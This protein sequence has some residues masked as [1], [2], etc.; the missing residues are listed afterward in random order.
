MRKELTSRLLTE[1]IF[2]LTPFPPFF[3]SGTS[4]G[5]E[6]FERCTVTEGCRS[7]ALVPCRSFRVFCIFHFIFVISFVIIWNKTFLYFVLIKWY[8]YLLLYFSFLFFSFCLFSIS[9]FGS[10]S[11][12][13]SLENRVMTDWYQSSQVLGY[14]NYGLLLLGCILQL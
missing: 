10:W 12:F 11:E 7:G 6:V 4:R 8:F 9:S 2:I 13:W 1:Y 3:S 14:P 5:G